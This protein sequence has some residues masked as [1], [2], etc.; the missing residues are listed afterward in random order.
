[1]MVES[2]QELSIIGV[3][4]RG[5]ANS[6]RIVLYAHQSLNLGQYGIMLGMRES[7]NSAFPLR[8]HL[9]WFG[10]GI[11]EPRTWLF[12][13]TG[14]GEARKTIMPNSQET[15]FVLHWGKPTTVLANLNIVPV[16]FR[17]EAVAVEQPPL[18]AK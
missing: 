9:F 1:M 14:P 5:V 2:I 15:A 4:D 16:L 8:D 11:I 17:V 12:I 18:L 6:E 7:E 10:D 3:F 13:Y